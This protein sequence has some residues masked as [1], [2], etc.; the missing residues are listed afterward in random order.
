MKVLL[1]VFVF[2]MSFGLGVQAFAESST[3]KKSV[4]HGSG[5]VF[6]PPINNLENAKSPGAVELVAP[7]FSSSISGQTQLKWKDVQD[8]E[9]YHLQIAKD[10]NFKWLVADEHMYKGTSFEL[11]NLE[12][13]LHYY[14]RVAATNQGKWPGSTKGAY[15]KSMFE[16]K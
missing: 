16:T 7:A 13:G 5:N 2:S 4:G 11:K 8:A 6:P 9:N 1:S 10:P 12:P 3:P 14:W 15:S